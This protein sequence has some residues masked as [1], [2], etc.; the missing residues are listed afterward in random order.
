MKTEPKHESLGKCLVQEVADV[1]SDTDLHTG[2]ETYTGAFTYDGEG[3]GDDL[4]TGDTTNPETLYSCESSNDSSVS[5]LNLK[6]QNGAFFL[7]EFS[8][9]NESFSSHYRFDKDVRESK[10]TEKRSRN[11]TID[12]HDLPSLFWEGTVRILW[13]APAL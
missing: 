2:E 9:D 1:C 12:L 7:T 11:R 8:S 4:R 6:S 5:T 10:L 3:T 13:S